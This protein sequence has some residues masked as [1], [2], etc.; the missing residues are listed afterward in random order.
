MRIDNVMRCFQEITQRNADIYVE[1]GKIV[2][3]PWKLNAPVEQSKIDMFEQKGYKI[4][5]ELKTIL[6]VS[7]GICCISTEHS[8][9]NIDTML[10]L[11]E[12]N[13]G[14]LIPGVYEFAYFLGDSLYIDSARIDSGNYILYE[15]KGF[16][17][18]LLL[19]YGITTFFEHLL[20]SN[21]SNYWRWVYEEREHI[22]FLQE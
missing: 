12:I 7:D 17:N 4:P 18:G 16:N 6:S 1:G 15:G 5:V 3:K 13:A 9:H 14:T 22:P 20:T 2:E 19:G 8:I 10:E 11:V 21:F